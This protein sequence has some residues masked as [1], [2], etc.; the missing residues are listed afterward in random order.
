MQQNIYM[1]GWFWGKIRTMIK[2]EPLTTIAEALGE[3]KFWECT[4]E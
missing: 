2:A 4:K 3:G 1:L